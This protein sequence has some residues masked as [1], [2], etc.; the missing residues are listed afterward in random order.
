MGIEEYKSIRDEMLQ[1]F[2]WDIELSFFAVGSTGALLSWLSTQSE[3]KQ[4]PYF[5]ICVGLTIVI[6]IFYS[7]YNVLKGIYNQGSYL[8]FFHEAVEENSGWHCLSRFRKELMGKRSDWGSNGRRG[9]WLLVILAL[10]NIFGPL[11]FLRGNINIC[12]YGDVDW[13]KM[14]TILVAVGLLIPVSKIA[15]GLFHSRKFMHENMREWMHVRKKLG[16][17][18][19]LLENTINKVIDSNATQK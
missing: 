3:S 16:Q 15:W 13:F 10:G 19:K 5:F 17:E 4:N 8:I 12:A 11:Y 14:V 1:R 18:P 2:R 7:Y 9:G 6:F